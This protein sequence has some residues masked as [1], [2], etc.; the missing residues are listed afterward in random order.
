MHTLALRTS[1]YRPKQGITTPGDVLL[2]HTTSR[3]L[4]S[5]LNPPNESVGKSLPHAD[6]DV[7]YAVPDSLA[8]LGVAPEG[9]LLAHIKPLGD[10]APQASIDDVR[11]IEI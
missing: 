3:R 5:R 8:I 10:K 7:N 2:L 1:T 6:G 11:S 4:T 9:L